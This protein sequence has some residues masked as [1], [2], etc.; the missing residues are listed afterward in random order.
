MSVKAWVEKIILPTYQA[1]KP[2]KNPMFLEKRVYQGS[3]G[4]VYPHPVI[5]SISDTKTDQEYTAVFLEN[6]Y[7]LI[8]VLPELGGRIQ[9]AYDKVRNRDFVYYNQVIKPAL[10]G[11]AGPWISGGIE[12]NWPQHH[13]PST[14][15]PIDHRI[16]EN[17]DGS[18]TVWVSETEIMFRTKGMA[19]F[20][21]YP[22]L[23]YLEIRGRLFN[24]TP[25]PQTFLWWANPAVKV[26]EHYQTIFPPDV[27]AVFDHGKRDVSDFP[28]ATGTYYK[29]NYAP[30]TDISKYS[31][32]PVPTSYM[33]I[34]SGYDFMGCYENDTRCGMLHVADHHLSPGKKQWTWG[35]GDFGYAWDR[36]LTDEDGPYIELMTGV[37]TDNQPDFSWM[38]PNEVKRFEQYFLPYALIGT[39]KNATKEAL[40]NMEADGT[41]LSVKVFATSLYKNAVVSLHRNGECI[42]T[43]SSDISPEQVF[44][45]QFDTGS[46]VDLPQWK[47]TVSDSRGNELVSWQP[48]VEAKKEIPASATKAKQPAEIEQVEELFLNGLHLEQYRHATYDP[49]AYYQEALHRSPGDVRCNNA[50]G[51]LLTRR[52]Q[53]AAAEKY[54]RNAIATLTMRNPNPYDGEA[55]YN[56]GWSLLLQGNPKD[57]YGFFYKATWNDAWQHSSFLSLAR[58]AA[59]NNQF[60]LAL[61][62]IDQSLVRNYHSLTARHLKTAILRKLGRHN[63]AQSLSA[64]SLRIDPFNNGCLY[65]AYLLHAQAGDEN[66]AALVLEKLQQQMRDNLNNYLE[67]SLDYAHAGCYKEA[68]DLLLLYAAG[69]DNTSP[70]PFLLPGLVC[71]AGGTERG[72]ATVLPAG[73]QS[74]CGRMFSQQNGR[75]PDPSGCI[76]VQSNRCHRCLCIG[77]FMVRQASIPGSHQLL[78][79]RIIT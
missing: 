21:L 20:T 51:L 68:T 41:V 64:E 62:H 46:V 74:K 23:A 29:V 77:Q 61:A 30:G 38:Q 39:V 3:S 43:Y 26:N 8:M 2:E 60:T 4:V 34:Q 42:T 40:L 78:G 67:L 56:L 24:R 50:M 18:K 25:F 10:V 44:E 54:F 70:L 55:F 15:S 14:F 79:K 57:A 9:R 36:N 71:F 75:N 45:E 7:L 1:G 17:E 32:I 66:A 35:N 69:Q 52:G 28:V 5:E 13:R 49:I 22:G 63:A 12:F 27:Y 6:E 11:L 72:S 73:R 37:F 53:F 59:G 65:E 48:E 19:G 47:I 76:A 16:E 31:T 58:I 33:A